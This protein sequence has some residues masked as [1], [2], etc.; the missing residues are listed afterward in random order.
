[1]SKAEG[2]KVKLSFWE[3]IRT[4]WKPYLRLY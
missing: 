2:A 3:T 4:A 1:M